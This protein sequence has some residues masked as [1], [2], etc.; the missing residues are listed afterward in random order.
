MGSVA[1]VSV[2]G[3]PVHTGTSVV[4]ASVVLALV[5]TSADFPCTGTR[6][7]RTSRAPGVVSV[8]CT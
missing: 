8:T 2:E 3:F 7:H 1:A 4:R 5:R 6:L